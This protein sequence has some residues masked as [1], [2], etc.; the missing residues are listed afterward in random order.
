[1]EGDCEQLLTRANVGGGGG[2]GGG[3]TGISDSFAFN[4]LADESVKTQRNKRRSCVRLLSKS[5]SSSSLSISHQVT[6]IHIG[7]FL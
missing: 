1:M 3:G 5:L 4:S 6:A 2:A 7:K